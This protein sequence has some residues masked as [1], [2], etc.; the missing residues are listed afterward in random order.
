[1]TF[2]A[3]RHIHSPKLTS[4]TDVIDIT[5]LSALTLLVVGGFVTVYTFV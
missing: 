3:I 1:M 5:F 2:F 4:W